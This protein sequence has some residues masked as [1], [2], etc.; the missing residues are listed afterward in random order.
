MIDKSTD[1]VQRQT[2]NTMGKVQAL[3]QSENVWKANEKVDRFL[4][5]QKRLEDALRKV[6]DQIET[7]TL[8]FSSDSFIKQM[9]NFEKE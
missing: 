3:K 2:K 4:N 7:Y 6:V 9:G 5:E 1:T 8:D